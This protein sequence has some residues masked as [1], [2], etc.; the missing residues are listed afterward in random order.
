MDLVNVFT[1]AHGT[2]G[3]LQGEGAEGADANTILN[4]TYNK[5][6]EIGRVTEVEVCVQTNLQEFHEVG[7]RHAVSLQPGDIHISGTI[8]RA[9]INGALLHLLLGRGANVT[10]IEE[11]YVQPALEMNVILNDPAVPGNRVILHLNGVKFQNW[12]Y[13]LPEDDFVMENVA[14]K[15][16][17]IRVQDEREGSVIEPEFPEA[18]EA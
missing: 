17:R 10:N 2:L 3:I 8:G 16:L 14:F 12:G 9:Y 4:D 18:G 5:I 13:S 15:A 6:N 7:Q 11:P 1:G